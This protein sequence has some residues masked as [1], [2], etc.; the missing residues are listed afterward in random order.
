MKSLS[1]IILVI[2]SLFINQAS[3]ESTL[4]DAIHQGDTSEVITLVSNGADLKQKDSEGHTV[5]SLVMFPTYTYNKFSSKTRL[6]LSALLLKKG[7]NPNF[8]TEYGNS[9]LHIAARGSVRRMRFLLEAGV[10]PN[11]QN[12]EGGTPLH[13]IEWNHRKRIELISLLLQYGAD[14]TIKNKKGEVARVISDLT[15]FKKLKSAFSEALRKYGINFEFGRDYSDELDKVV[16]FFK[17]GLK[18][19]D[20]LEEMKIADPR[21]FTYPM[22]YLLK[23]HGLKLSNIPNALH[24]AAYVGDLNAVKLLV[25][26]GFDVNSLAESDGKSRLFYYSNNRTPLFY[27][28]LSES[29]HRKE[30]AA[31]LLKNSADLNAKDK[32]KNNA[33]SLSIINEDASENLSLFLLEKGSDYKEMYKGLT[34]LNAAVVSGKLNILKALIDKGME[35]KQLDDENHSLLHFAVKE[36]HVGIVSYLLEQGLDANQKDKDGNTSLYYSAGYKR[37]PKIASLLLAHSADINAINNKQETSLHRAAQSNNT[38]V[39]SLLTDK[40][41]DINAKSS[42]GTTPLLLAIKKQNKEIAKLLIYKGADKSIQNNKQQTPEKIAIEKKMNVASLFSVKD[43]DPVTETKHLFQAVNK[44]DIN[45]LGLLMARGAKLTALNK[46]G[47]TLLFVSDDPEMIEFLI[48]KGVDMGTKD[49]DGKTAIQIHFKD[50]TSSINWKAIKTLLQHGA[51]GNIFNKDK[52]SLLQIA[53]NDSSAHDAIINLLVK[54]IKDVN[55]YCSAEKTYWRSNQNHKTF[56]K[57][58]KLLFSKGLDPN[59]TTDKHKRT[60][61]HYAIGGKSIYPPNNEIAKLALD[62][63]ANPDSQDDSGWTALHYA[64]AT[65]NPEGV[66]I[67]IDA[68]SQTNLTDAVKLTPLDYAKLFGEKKIINLLKGSSN[69]QQ[70]TPVVKLEPQSKP[71]IKPEIKTNDKYDRS[72]LHKAVFQGNI[73]QIKK[74]L[75]SGF[76]VNTK[77]KLGRTPLH[78]TASRGYVEIAQLL[79][80]KGA[81]INGAD[82]AK[83]WTPLFFAAFMHH[84]EMMDILIKK[85]ADQTLKD[86]FNRTASDYF[87]D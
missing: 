22:L 30:I 11:I 17:L 61:L 60:L 78:Y 53:L 35:I 80:D 25:S 70:N 67:L 69:N 21:V 74:L 75:E 59:P 10:N 71:D 20:I 82:K 7:A 15:G 12:K 63:K 37:S 57:Y 27:T 19:D 84:K 85:G 28:A 38:L 31:F 3:A 4:V 51:D 34:L 68:K 55:A 66:Q 29:P 41:I 62:H 47:Q 46:N 45:K 52:N 39:A 49:K 81:D 42:D 87:K 18:P 56:L 1:I 33:F 14:P 26:L 2:S 24:K 23:T 8:I 44:D 40:G 58:Y 83:Q 6:Q 77:D 48:S 5:L 32:N 64:V 9:L 36:E 16:L 13:E 79:L 50:K 54:K 65:N 86:K 43:F 76:G 73:E 72:E